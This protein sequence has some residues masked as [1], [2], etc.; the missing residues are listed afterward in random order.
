M[1]DET[2][3]Y[4]DYDFTHNNKQDVSGI[5]KT[6]KTQYIQLK[7]RTYDITFAKTNYKNESDLRYCKQEPLSSVLTPRF[8]LYWSL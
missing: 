6:I 2:Q 3:H 8:E 7:L 1:N 5:L 4:K